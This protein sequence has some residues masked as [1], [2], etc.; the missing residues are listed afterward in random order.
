[1]NSKHK[2]I[3]VMLK[4]LPVPNAENILSGILPQREHDAIYYADVQQYD[5]LYV[6]E[7]LKCSESNV[8]KIRQSGYRKLATFLCEN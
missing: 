1:M 4:S 6:A 3:R 8:K 7:L 5:L 2:T